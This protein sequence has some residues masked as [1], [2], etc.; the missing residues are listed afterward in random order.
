MVNQVFA[1]GETC[2][3][4][5]HVYFII[6][7]KSRSYHVELVLDLAEHHPELVCLGELLDALL[8]QGQRLL[9]SKD[10]ACKGRP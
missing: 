8:Y 6:P 1:V 3:K 9:Q 7:L 10:C 5:S 2:K 4:I